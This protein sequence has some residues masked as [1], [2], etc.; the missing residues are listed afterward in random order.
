MKSIKM[1]ALIG[2][3]A[4]ML[5][6]PAASADTITVSDTIALTT[7]S[8]TNTLDFTQF[9]SSLGTL[10]SVELSLTAVADTQLYVY[11]NH[12]SQ[13]RIGRAYAALTFTVQ[14]PISGNLVIPVIN[15]PSSP[16]YA[17]DLMG[18]AS[19]TSG[20][21]NYPNTSIFNTLYTATDVLA[22]FTGNGT[23]SLNASAGLSGVAGANVTAT[24]LN[25][26]AGLVGTVIYTC[27]PAV[28]PIPGSVMLLGSGLVGL[29][30]LRFR[31]RG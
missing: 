13:E 17:Y 29:G 18:H 28:V 25:P 14:A 27:T 2:I 10:T 5:W 30:L 3:L 16:D 19:A 21:F 1:T 22:V 6:V 20:V 24:P 23:E 31:R 26:H 4:L 7:A 8:W 11:N 9:D 12:T 15:F